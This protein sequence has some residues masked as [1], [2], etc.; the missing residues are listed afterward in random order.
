VELPEDAA[1]DLPVVPPGLVPPEVGWQE[2]LQQGEGLVSEFQH[3]GCSWL[4]GVRNA[5]LS[6]GTTIS[7]QVRLQC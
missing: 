4:V 6:A 5:T 7:S 3:R 1:E 2:Q